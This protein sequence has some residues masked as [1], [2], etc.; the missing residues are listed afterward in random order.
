LDI[1]YQF[2]TPN[3]PLNGQIG[4]P[5]IVDALLGEK[6]K[7]FFIESGAFDG[8]GLTNTLFFEKEI[9]LSYFAIGNQLLKAYFGQK[10]CLSKMVI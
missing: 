2:K 9:H 6:Q 8:E 1:P 7:G 3:P 4:V 10:M 5:L